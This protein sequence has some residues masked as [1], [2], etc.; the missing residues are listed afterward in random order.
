MTKTQIKRRELI[1]GIGE[2]LPP[3]QRPSLTIKDAKKG[4]YLSVKGETCFVEEVATYT[5][6]KWDSFSKKKQDYLIT[7]LTLFNISTGEKLYVEWEEDDD[8][9]CCITTKEL[10][11]RD[12][13][14]DGVTA[15]REIVE[16]IADEEEGELLHTP[17]GKAFYYSEDDTYAALYNSD[18]YTDIPVRMY[19]FE[20]DNG[21]YLTIEFWYDDN[22]DI[23]PSKEAYLSKDLD[24]HDIGILKV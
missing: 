17:S 14:Y 9:E 15:S 21:D 5:E 24:I 8:I 16:E 6:V 4:S 18:K 1:Y 22:E 19:E 3:S 13:K 23:K 11:L 2:V 10:S 12:F 20:S 7:E